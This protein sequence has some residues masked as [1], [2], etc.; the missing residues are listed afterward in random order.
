MPEPLIADLVVID[1]LEQGE[2]LQRWSRGDTKL[3]TIDD[4]GAGLSLA[5]VVINPM[6]CAWGR[7]QPSSSS[8]ALYEGPRYAILAPGIAELAAREVSIPPRA[9]RVLLA[10]G[11]SD[12]HA[13]TPRMLDALRVVPGPFT[14]RVNQPPAGSY[15]AGTHSGSALKRAMRDHPQR[16]EQVPQDVSFFDELAAAEL[17]LCAGG[18][19]LLELAALGVPAAAVAGEPHERHNVATFAGLGSCLDLGPHESLQPAAIA[20]SVSALMEDRRRREAMSAAGR[21]AV[22]GRGL[23]RVVALIDKLWS[24]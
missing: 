22:D 16:I 3:L 19:M 11:G 2:P 20:A 8:A 9:T 6:V 15:S 24:S 17:V 12:D 13:I 14:V 18:S 5:D 23:E 1:M 7:Y 21:A 4:V 10:Y